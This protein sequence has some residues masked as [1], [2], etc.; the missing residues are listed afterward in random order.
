MSR[1]VPAVY[2]IQKLL[3]IGFSV[4]DH[5]VLAYPCY[6][7]VFEAALDDL[8]E[9]VRREQLVYIGTRKVIRERLMSVETM[10]LINLTQ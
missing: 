7:M 2:F 3:R 8:M 5:E 1:D 10:W 4:L 9:E 6:Q